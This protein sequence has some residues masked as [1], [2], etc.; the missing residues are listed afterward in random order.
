LTDYDQ[1]LGMSEASLKSLL[2]TIGLRLEEPQ[3]ADRPNKAIERFLEDRPTFRILFTGR[4]RKKLS[5]IMFPY[6]DDT[7][8]SKR[9]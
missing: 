7:W 8:G 3:M 9:A 1:F 4:D 6:A 2:S 5:K